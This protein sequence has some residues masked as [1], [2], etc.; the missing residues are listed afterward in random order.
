MRVRTLFTI[1]TL[2]SGISANAANYYFSASEGNDSRT[3]IQAQNP[4]TPW[5]SINQLNSFFPSLHPGD[6][7]LFK[8][9]DTFYGSIVTAQ[10][11]TPSAPITISSYGSG[12]KPVITGF[13]TVAN[14]TYLGNGIYESNVLPAGTQLN[15][16]LIN[17]TQ[18]AIGRYPNV[19]DKNGGYL[20]FESFGSDWIR[21]N[22]NSLTPKWKGAQLVVR[23]SHYTVEK[24]I[25]TKIAGNTIS[26]SPS[27]VMPLTNNYG[28]FVQNNIKTLDQFGEWCYNPSTQ[29]IDVYFGSSNPSGS[30]VQVSTRDILLTI[31]SSNMVVDNIAFKGANTYGVWG[32]WAGVSNLQVKNCSIDFS[33][34]DGL[35][36][37]GRHNFVLDN[38]TISNSNSVGVSLFYKNYNPVVKNSTIRNSGTSAGMMQGDGAKRYGF[39]IY[40]SEGLTATN[41]N[42]INTG[43]VGIM[44][45]GDSNLIQNNY[46]DTFCTVL[47][48]G[49][50]I[51]TNNYTPK[52]Q[53][54]APLYSLRIIGNIVLHGMGAKTGS[55]ESD[56]NYVPAEGIYLDDNVMSAQVLNNTV[57]YC[58]NSGI[59]VHNTKNYTLMGNVLYDNHYRQIAFQHDYLGDVIT[60]GIIKQNQLF[61][62]SAPEYILYLG[63][64]YNDMA[65]F[66]TFDS[67]YYCRPSDENN[68]ILTNWFGNK[69][70]SYNLPAWQAAYNTDRN[71]KGT[72]V[73]VTD[74]N[75]VLFLYNASTSNS[76]I[77]LNGTY[78]SVPGDSYSG[79]VTLAP[80]TSIILLKTNSVNIASATSSMN[81]SAAA[82]SNTAVKGPG[83][84]NTEPP[85]LAVKAYPN[86]GSHYFNVTTQGGSTSEPMTFKILDLSGRVLQVKTGI[87]ANSTFQIGRDLASGSYIMQLFQGNNK[88]EQKVIKLVK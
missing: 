77:P 86:P 80:F 36:L 55:Y 28:Y 31:E 67:N 17:G 26:Y 44:F 57:A 30:T 16:L 73:P 46:V 18:Y 25:I 39:G 74:P 64:A 83:Y 76:T 81:A 7:V 4:S 19:S 51:Y 40:S 49:G 41:N 23:T 38:T 42:V 29:K 43:F 8:S 11:G 50:G 52:G 47:D 34:I 21:D 6:Q 71:S 24:S 70:S 14:W 85:K 54:P 68:I 15:M 9:G 10:S 88:V 20:T 82:I 59:Y 32:N 35:A 62:K 27:F 66:G 45:E 58:S 53:Q 13:T 22:R 48:D 2:T 1:L 63:S 84:I 37:A 5:Q 75:S 72:P 78:V 65:G 33:G 3:S 12:A 61:A 79:S 69:Q 87:T 60:G 56:P